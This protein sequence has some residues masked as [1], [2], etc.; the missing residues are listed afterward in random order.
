MERSKSRA[1][2]FGCQGDALTALLLILVV[3]G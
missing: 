2:D 1:S 3:L